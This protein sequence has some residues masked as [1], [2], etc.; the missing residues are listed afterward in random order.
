MPCIVLYTEMPVVL[1][2]S[3]V[4]LKVTPFHADFQSDGDKVEVMLCIEHETKIST[5]QDPGDV[6][7]FANQTRSEALV[8]LF[9]ECLTI[10]DL[11][12]VEVVRD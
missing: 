11:H 4:V 8:A 12:V 7:Q 3:P 5:P 1:A 9:D 2:E 10:K 6:L